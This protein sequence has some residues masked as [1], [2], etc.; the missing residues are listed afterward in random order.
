ML[1]FTRLRPL[2][3]QRPI[4]DLTLLFPLWYS[5]ASCPNKGTGREDAAHMIPRI[6]TLV[7]TV[8]TGIFLGVPCIAYASETLS[9][10]PLLPLVNVIEQDR[11]KEEASTSLTGNLLLDTLKQQ[12]TTLDALPDLT[13]L[14][15][16]KVNAFSIDSLPVDQESYYGISTYFRKG[17]PALDMRAKLGSPVRSILPG[18]VKEVGFE[19]YGYGNYVIVA[20]L[21]GEKTV[22]LLYAHMQRV[23]AKSGQEVK[24]LD[25]IGR[26]GMTGHTTGPHLHLEVHQDDKAVDPIALI[27]LNPAIALAK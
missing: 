9:T 8:V 5:T 27:K 15:K 10:Q 17:H 21:N 6:N 19:T 7:L 13:K 25:E 3:H 18:I 24:A 22:Y 16:T 2:P 26:I 4:I 12:D 1:C 20:H 23:T 11:P 14:T